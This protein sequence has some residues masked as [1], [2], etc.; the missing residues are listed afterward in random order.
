MKDKHNVILILV[1]S[2][3]LIPYPGGSSKFLFSFAHLSFPEF[4]VSTLSRRKA[5]SKSLQ[6]FTLC[7]RLLFILLFFCYWSSS[8]RFYMIVHQGFIS[9][10]KCSSRFFSKELKHS[11]SCNPECISFYLIFWD[12]VMS[13]L[14]IWV[15]VSWFPC[16]QDWDI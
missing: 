5:S 14:T 10:S 2:K 1:S 9:F 6:V 13:L 16:C 3:W 15:C 11:S 12:G 4:Q 7:F 8:W